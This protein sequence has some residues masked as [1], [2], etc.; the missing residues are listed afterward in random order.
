MPCWR[1]SPRGGQPGERRDRPK[2][3]R[4]TPMV[5]TGIE[6]FAADLHQEVL[7]R[8][9]DEQSPALREEAFTEHVLG[10]LT[11]HDE[12]SGAEPCAFEARGT[13][14]SPAAKLNAWALSGDGATLDLFVC[15]YF[16]TGNVELV[17]KPDARR[18]FE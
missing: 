9:G 2:D 5:S 13:G 16:G 3:R 11:E 17:T 8:A 6:Q 18:H 10:L 15:R 1:G 12:T 7:V 14:R 4:P